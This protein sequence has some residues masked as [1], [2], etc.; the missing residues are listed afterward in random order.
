MRVTTTSDVIVI[1]GG[2]AGLAAAGELARRG[3]AVTLLEARDRLGG[4][5]LT[6]RPKGWQKPVELGAEFI[7]G[8]NRVFWARMR[9]QGLRA[10]DVPS[11]HWLFYRD[12]LERIDDVD[13]RICRVTE[14]IAP[15]RMEGWSFADF[16]RRHS[17]SFSE[18][19]RNLAQGFVEGFQA[20]SPQQMSAS[21]IAD[22]TLREEE[23]FRVPDGYD[24]FVDSLERELRRDGVTVHLRSPVTRVAWRRERVT[25]RASG[26]DFQAKVAI[27]TLPLGVWLAKAPQR[28]A[29]TFAPP[30]RE[31]RRVVGK[32]GVG[33]VVRLT[34]RFDAR[35]WQKILP[36][37]LRRD[38]RAGFGF[39]HSRLTGVPVWWAMSGAPVLTGWAGGPAATR[40]SGL[41]K[42]AVFEKAL[43]SL[44]RIFDRP[45]E[46]VRSAVAGWEMHNW[47]RDPF[48]RCAYSFSAAGQE[49]AAAKLREPVQDT[50]FFAGEAT[51]N[52]GEVGTV[53]GALASGLR[54]AEDVRRALPRG[55]TPRK[56]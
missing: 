5:I 6:V 27:V 40:L 1:G 46:E 36:P 24:Q 15:R 9:K 35:R 41:S 51:A 42:R 32:M 45:K 3:Y 56:S 11:R 43:A 16:M 17:K 22:E 53:H 48:S 23:Q 52:G 2:V 12:A 55:K 30:L 50:L 34:V 19:D 37:A 26:C 54:A 47:S 31:K 18:R 38:A 33:Q 4:R 10:G 29:V 7:H 49:N 20:A 39:I 21:A 28:G 14:R 8:G 13:D 25:V 44:S